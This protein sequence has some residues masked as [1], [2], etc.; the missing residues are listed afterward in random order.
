[1]TVR[2]ASR[3]FGRSC[4]LAT[5]STRSKGRKTRACCSAFEIS[6]VGSLNPRLKP[7]QTPETDFHVSQ[8]LK[9]CQTCKMEHEQPCSLKPWQEWVIETGPEELDGPHD[10]VNADGASAL[11][12]LCDVLSQ[13]GKADRDP[14]FVRTD[15]EVTMQHA[16]LSSEIGTQDAREPDTKV[17]VDAAFLAFQERLRNEPDQVLRYYYRETADRAGPLWVSDEKTLKA[18]DVPNCKCGAR[19]IVEFQVRAHEIR[20]E[21]TKRLTEGPMGRSSRLYWASWAST[22]WRRTRWTLAR[23]SST[24]ARRP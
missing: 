8:D 21:R 7:K 12:G 22:T 18:E 23:S 14:K 24:P 16:T 1:M 20:E 17:P 6:N 2:A 19:R 9:F 10:P 5:R 11:S 4:R 3:F 15:L 13:L